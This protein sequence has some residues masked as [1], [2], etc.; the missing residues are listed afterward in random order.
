VRVYLPIDKLYV[1]DLHGKMIQAP[2][3]I[4]LSKDSQK[5]GK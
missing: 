3:Y 5:G 2:T 4:T 1:F